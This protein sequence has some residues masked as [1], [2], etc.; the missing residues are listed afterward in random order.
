MEDLAELEQVCN[1]F[2][3]LK[4]VSLFVGIFSL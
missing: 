4:V 3:A 1:N 2:I